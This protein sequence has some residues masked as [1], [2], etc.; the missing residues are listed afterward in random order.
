MYHQAGIEEGQVTQQKLDYAYQWEKGEN[1]VIGTQWVEFVQIGYLEI[2]G[3]YVAPN[4]VQNEENEESLVVKSYARIAEETVVISL[5]D[6][7]IALG[8][9]EGARWSVNLQRRR[10]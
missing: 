6:A 7:G 4:H 1:L 10:L 9:V 5:Q 2:Q 8:A 3:K